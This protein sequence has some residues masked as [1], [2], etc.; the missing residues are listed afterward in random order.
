MCR[1][2]RKVVLRATLAFGLVVTFL[3]SA[4]TSMPHN[5]SVRQCSV[6]Q[7]HDV[8]RH[9]NCRKQADMSQF[10]IEGHEPLEQQ[11][12]PFSGIVMIARV[13]AVICICFAVPLSYAEVAHARGVHIH[14]HVKVARTSMVVAIASKETHHQ[15]HHST[16]D[17][18]A[19][20]AAE[21]LER[22]T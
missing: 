6:D 11:S 15:H 8:L 1:G 3:G 22:R 2:L 17:D 10:T 21:T 20:P 7:A 4:F 14:P 9:V 16:H 18:A 13:A 5:S 19:L 12:N